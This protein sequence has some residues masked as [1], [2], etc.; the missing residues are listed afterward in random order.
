[1]YFLKDAQAPI[2]AI[3]LYNDLCRRIVTV[4]LEPGTRISEN[5]VSAEYGVSRSVLR[6][7]FARLQQTNLI[8]VYPQRGTY[9]KRLDMEYIRSAAM[10][11]Y[12]VERDAVYD[13]L[14][15]GRDLT[16][17]CAD[18]EQMLEAMRRDLTGGYEEPMSDFRTCNAEFHLRV[19]QECF[20]AHTLSLLYE[21]RVHL[22]RWTNIDVAYQGIENTVVEQNAAILDAIREGRLQRALRNIKAHFEMLTC[23]EQMVRELHPGYFESDTAPERER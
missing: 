4:E 3:G 17:L 11:R 21:M 9:V 10:I 18:L 23:N 15:S 2:S 7:A 20:P 13:L 12:V 1:M 14:Q 19:I 5:A 8:E 6:T 16:G 22:T